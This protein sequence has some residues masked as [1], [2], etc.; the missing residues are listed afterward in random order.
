M[1]DRISPGRKSAH[2][3]GVMRFRINVGLVAVELTH[4]GYVRLRRRERHQCEY[5]PSPVLF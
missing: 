3:A 2:Y 5:G 4:V 1:T